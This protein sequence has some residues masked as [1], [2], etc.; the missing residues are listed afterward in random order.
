MSSV[1][2]YNS[3]SFRFPHFFSCFHSEIWFGVSLKAISVVLLKIPHFIGEKLGW[4]SHNSVLPWKTIRVHQNYQLKYFSLKVTFKTI[5]TC[6]HVS[7]QRNEVSEF[8][9]IH[10]PIIK[11][12]PFGMYVV[13]EQTINPCQ[14]VLV[15]LRSAAFPFLRENCANGITPCAAARNEQAE[16]IRAR[17]LLI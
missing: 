13:A 14:K 7:K 15:H 2:C 9:V 10:N 3:V 11:N 17:I 12:C 1:K 8:E 16:T 6:V 5:Y 4:I